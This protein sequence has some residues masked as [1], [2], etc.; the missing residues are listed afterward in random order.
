[1]KLSVNPVG[2]N[3]SVTFNFKESLCRFSSFKP[4]LSPLLGTECFFFLKMEIVRGYF[5]ISGILSF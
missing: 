3:Y 1:M 4:A 2:S 5:E